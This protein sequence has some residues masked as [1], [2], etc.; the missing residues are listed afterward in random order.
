MVTMKLRF[1]KD[2]RSAKEGQIMDVNEANAKNLI[3]KKIAVE[4]EEAK[5]TKEVK[6]VKRKAR[7]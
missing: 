2:Y 4:V 3:E 1:L 5:K 6:A 7:K